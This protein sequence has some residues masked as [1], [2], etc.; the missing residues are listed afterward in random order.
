M[1]RFVEVHYRIKDGKRDAFY[2][3]LQESGIPA[4]SRAESGNEKYEYYFNPENENEL[5]LLEIW[6]SPEAVQIHAQTEHFQKLGKLKEQY[7]TE[8]VIKRFAFPD[9]F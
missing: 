2:R 1:K 5:L 8:T 9:T 3:A 4:A 6:T 7:V